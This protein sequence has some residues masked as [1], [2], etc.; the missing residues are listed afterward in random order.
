M[1]KLTWTLVATEVVP[2]EISTW[3][4]CFDYEGQTVVR[5]ESIGVDMGSTACLAVVASTE[6]APECTMT[7]V[8]GACA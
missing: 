5:R 2:V 6:P 8:W 3:E 1:D 4:P 7:K